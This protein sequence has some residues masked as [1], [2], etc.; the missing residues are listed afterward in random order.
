MIIG[1]DI[2]CNL[3]RTLVIYTFANVVREMSSIKL[4]KQFEL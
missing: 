1:C 4:R 2:I 3:I